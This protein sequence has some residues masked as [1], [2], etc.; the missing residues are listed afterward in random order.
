ML[1]P[2]IRTQVK[3]LLASCLR[4]QLSRPLL[5]LSVVAYETISASLFPIL[6]GIVTDGGVDGVPPPIIAIRESAC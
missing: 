3:L 1:F 4:T 5:S 2:H 6:P